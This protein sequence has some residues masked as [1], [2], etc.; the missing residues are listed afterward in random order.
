M[1]GVRGVPGKLLPPI[2]EGVLGM[3][4]ERLR[5]GLKSDM[6]VGGADPLGELAPP[7]PP[8]SPAGERGA[9]AGLLMLRWGEPFP[10]SPVAPLEALESRT[11]EGVAAGAPGA[12]AGGDVA[13]GDEGRGCVGS[14]VLLPA[15]AA[16]ASASAIAESL[17]APPSGGGDGGLDGIGLA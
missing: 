7:P 8:P 5:S 3:D 10:P 9:S 2:E 1:K 14:S 15:A 12:G 4:P 16:A 17:A 6:G 11:E 13:A